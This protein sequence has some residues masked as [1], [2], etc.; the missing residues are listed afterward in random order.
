MERS[1]AP[2]AQDPGRIRGMFGAI[3]PSYDRL[4]HLLSGSLDKRWRAR[5]ARETLRSLAPCRRVLDVATGTGDLA[6]AL[7]RGAIRELGADAAAAIEWVGSDFTRAMLSQAGVKYPHP[8][9]HW[10]EGDGLHLPFASDAFDAATVAFGLRNMAD[11]PLALRELA[12]VVRPGG[13]VA[14]LEFGQPR[15]PL[16]RAAYDWYSFSVLPRIGKLLSGSEAYLY[17]ADSIRKFYNAEQ[18]S[19][20]MRRAGMRDVRAI[21]LLFGVVYLHVGVVEG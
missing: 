9:M 1:P 17:L 19:E 7:R 8:R 11:K 12:R 5:A 20:E 21:A 15:Q 13:R 18:L 4:N 2:H 3:A 16:F 10:V 14:I 6:E